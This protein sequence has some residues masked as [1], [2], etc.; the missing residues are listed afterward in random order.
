MFVG[1]DNNATYDEFL[2]DIESDGAGYP[3][4][5]KPAVL[6]SRNPNGDPGNGESAGGWI[7][8]A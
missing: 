7:S 1:N 3:I 4:G 2:F 8:A 5:V 6:A